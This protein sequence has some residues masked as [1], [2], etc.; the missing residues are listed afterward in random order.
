MR[1]F[2][3]IV[4]AA[5]VMLSSTKG[6]AENVGRVIGGVVYSALDTYI[7]NYPINAYNYEGYQLVC[8]EDLRDYGFSVIWNEDA[9]ALYV[10]R[11]YSITAISGKTGVTRQYYLQYKKAYDILETDIKVYINGSQVEGYAVDG[12]TMIKIRDLEVFGHCEYSAENN[13][14]KVFIDGLAQGEYAPVPIEYNERLTVVLDPGHGKSSFLMSDEE[15]IAEGYSYH[16]GQWGEWRHWKNGTANK[17]CCGSGCNKDY[18]CFYPIGNGN[19]DVEPDIDLQNALYAKWYLENELGYNVRMTRMSNEQNPSFS[20]R[21]SYCY[22]GN[23]IDDEPDAACYICIHSNAGGGRGTAYISAKGNY[24]QKWIK[25][26][27]IA[28]SNRL[29]ECINNRIVA[30][31]SLTRHGSGSING[32]GHLILFNKCPITV[33]YLEIGFFD[34]KSDLGILNSQ[35]NEIGKAI[36][37]G[38]NDFLCNY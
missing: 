34:N 14:S 4:V 25:S 33:G 10:D 2:M 22:P 29:G 32:A 9:R 31:T 37:Y 5:V 3:S 38:I 7:N 8:A 36:A 24:T 16:N 17:E 30:Q 35:H 23:N 19:R 27:Y 15:K 26:N 13:Y 11:D 28:E 12:K 18:S 21:I 6:F 20:K 1:I